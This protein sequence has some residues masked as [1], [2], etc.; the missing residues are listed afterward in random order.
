MWYFF[1]S[2]IASRI[3]APLVFHLRIANRNKHKYSLAKADSFFNYY[4]SRKLPADK[5]ELNSLVGLPS[6]QIIRKVLNLSKASFNGKKFLKKSHSKSMGFFFL[7][8]SLAD[9]YARSMSEIRRYRSISANSRTRL[10]EAFRN[11]IRFNKNVILKK[12]DIE[13]KGRSIFVYYIQK[14]NWYQRK[15]SRPFTLMASK[16]TPLKYKYDARLHALV[17]VYG[18]RKFAA[19]RRRARAKHYRQKVFIRKILRRRF[20]CNMRALHTR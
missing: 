1:R 10:R 19:V 4:E 14:K 16:S 9:H 17:S 3:L 6:R 12:R 7:R 2:N 13:A 20:A 8:F 15:S 11:I 18:F 5:Q